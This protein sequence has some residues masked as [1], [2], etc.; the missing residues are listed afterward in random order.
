MPQLTPNLQPD[1]FRALISE[2]STVVERETD[3]HIKVSRS[4]DALRLLVAHDDWLPDD[5]RQV[6]PERYQQYLLY[7]DPQE[8]FCVVSFVWGPG[9]STP[10]HDHRTWGAIGILQGMEVSQSYRRTQA[11]TIEVDGP[12]ITLKKGDVE[13][14]LPGTNDIHCVSNGLQSGISISIHVYGANIGSLNRFTYAPD[15]T[16]KPFVSYFSNP[17][18]PNFWLP[19]AQQT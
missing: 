14:L 11:D 19:I 15:G 7:C 2:L 5:Y 4:A 16:P 9:Q 18:L 10:V 17:H 13:T 6:N 1:R 3:E 8:R 12:P